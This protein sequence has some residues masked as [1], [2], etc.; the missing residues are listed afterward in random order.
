MLAIA[1]C[2]KTYKR[3]NNQCKIAEIAI[4]EA[5]EAVDFSNNSPVDDEWFE[6][7][8]ESAAY[9]SEA[10]MQTI[11]GKV[12]AGEFERP[13]STPPTLI[14][15]LSEINQLYA[16]AFQIICSTAVDIYANGIYDESLVFLPRN[17][18]YLN[19]YG[20]NLCALEELSCLGLLT[21][22]P[23]LG[24]TSNFPSSVNSVTLTYGKESCTFP[25]KDNC[26]P[27]GIAILTESGNCLFKYTERIHL[28]NHFENIKK[29]IEA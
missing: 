14:R 16:K 25:L 24:F 22:S 29:M 26:I 15:I 23:V 11:W 13:G 4:N 17:Y 3:L 20:I 5:S 8:M 7:F 28:K 12:L 2:K 21:L 19:E 27:F 6:R 10:G 9:V 1:N 18:D